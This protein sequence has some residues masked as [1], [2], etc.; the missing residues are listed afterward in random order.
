MRTVSKG[1]MGLLLASAAFAPVAAQAQEARMDRPGRGDGGGRDFRDRGGAQQM[2]TRDFAQE[3]EERARL[4]PQEPSREFQ[5]PRQDR[6]TPPTPAPQDRRDFRQGQ[7]DRNQLEQQRAN[8]RRDFRNDRRDDRQDF[9]ADR[10]DWNDRRDWGRNDRRDWS[11]DWRS[12]RRY[13]WQDYRR[14]N[15]SIYRVPRYVGPRGYA[16]SYRRWSP[17]FR[18]DPWFYG[19]SY[20]INDPWGYRLPPAYGPY[21][22]VRYYDD[23]ILVDIQTGI[24]RDIIYDFFW[25]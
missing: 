5:P 1:L 13:A 25:R 3:R 12:D 24:V 20:W 21:R 14:D 17:G 4:N 8:D 2:G 23:V 16:Y 9:R 15:R 11:R 7:I 6:P 10:R 19:N 22:W 18:I